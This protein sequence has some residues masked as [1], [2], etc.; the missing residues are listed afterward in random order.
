MINYLTGIAKSTQKVVQAYRGTT[1][2]PPS[3]AAQSQHNQEVERQTGHPAANVPLKMPTCTGRKFRVHPD[4]TVS[5]EAAA[6]Q[7]IGK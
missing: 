5:S 1:N 6:G 7:P 3:L 2:M 4:G